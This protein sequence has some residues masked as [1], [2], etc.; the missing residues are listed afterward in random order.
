MFSNC[1]QPSMSLHEQ[2]DAGNFFFG[3]SGGIIFNLVNFRDE[4][5]WDWFIDLEN[6]KMENKKCYLKFSNPVA[7]I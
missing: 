4:F 5:L 7:P 3:R 6:S 2:R 1:Y